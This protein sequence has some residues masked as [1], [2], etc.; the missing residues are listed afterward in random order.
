VAAPRDAVLVSPVTPKTVAVLCGHPERARAL[1]EEM[2]TTT[3][4]LGTALWVAAAL[5]GLTADLIA[6]DDEQGGDRLLQEAI[7]VAGEAVQF[8][9]PPLLT[10]ADLRLRQGHFEAALDTA[11]EAARAGEEYLVVALMPAGRK[12]R[13]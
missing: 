9:I 13:R 5:A 6:L 10:R 12:A 3:R 7:D 11:R 4:E 1:H 2:L 8:V